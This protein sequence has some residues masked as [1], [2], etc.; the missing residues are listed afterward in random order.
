MI[1]RRGKQFFLQKSTRPPPVTPCE[2]LFNEGC[3]LIFGTILVSASSCPCLCPGA[4]VGGPLRVSLGYSAVLCSHVRAFPREF[5][6]GAYGPAGSAFDL[7]V[8]RTLS[9]SQSQR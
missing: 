2:R 7:I 6:F 9:R 3:T 1:H 5:A 4:S 8:L